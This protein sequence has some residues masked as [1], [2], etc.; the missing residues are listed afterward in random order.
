MGLVSDDKRQA[1]EHKKILTVNSSVQRS[2]T[3]RGTF[4][5]KQQ[6]DGLHGIAYICERRRLNHVG[7]V[8][9]TILSRAPTSLHP[10]GG[11]PR[12]DF[13]IDMAFPIG[14]TFLFKDAFRPI[15]RM[16][17]LTAVYSVT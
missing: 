16:I 10:R 1:M 4:S 13:K 8:R 12:P 14:S 3:A 5:E 11:W 17:P 2:S 15:P 6:I 7:I 9:C